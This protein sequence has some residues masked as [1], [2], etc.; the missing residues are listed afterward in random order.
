MPIH[1]CDRYQL[2]P[3]LCSE[4]GITKFNAHQILHYRSIDNLMVGQNI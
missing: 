3:Y 2:S 1:V 4:D